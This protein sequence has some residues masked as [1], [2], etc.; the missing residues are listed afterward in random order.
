MKK[1]EMTIPHKLGPLLLAVLAFGCGASP[2]PLEGEPPLDEEGD[3]ALENDLDLVELA[4]LEQ[5]L[6]SSCG[7][8]SPNRTMNASYSNSDV[9]SG[10][11]RFGFVS[12]YDTCGKGYFVQVERYKPYESG[13]I[14]VPTGDFGGISREECNSV[15]TRL[16]AWQK[17]T[18]GTFS[19]VDSYQ[20]GGAFR[21][22]VCVQRFDHVRQDRL[23]R[24]LRTGATVKYAL[25][26]RRANDSTLPVRMAT[27]TIVR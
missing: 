1:S 16:Y 13:R 21:N 23:E 25:T 18:N 5:A 19:F 10:L 7:E 9:A 12:G 2:A 27:Q 14:G 11:G 22:G 15:I 24:S 20:Q 6:N 4:T 3:E 26:A 17:E 8:S